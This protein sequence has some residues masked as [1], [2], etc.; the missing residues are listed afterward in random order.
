MQSTTGSRT[1]HS[2]C[3]PAMAMMRAMPAGSCVSA[4]SPNARRQRGSSAAIS[5]RASGHS[6]PSSAIAAAMMPPKRV[7]AGP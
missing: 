4:S 6:A 1:G 2:C 3:S 5:D 7:A